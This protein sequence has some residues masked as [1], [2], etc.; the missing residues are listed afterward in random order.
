MRPLRIFAVLGAVA[1]AWTALPAAAEPPALRV[2]VACTL[3]GTCTLQHYVDTAPDQ[4]V[5]DYRCGRLSYQGHEGTDIRVPT[6]AAM[7][8]GVP[9]IAA[10][11][12]QVKAV[13]DGMPDAFKDQLTAE[14]LADRD[15]GNGVLIA[16]GDGWVTQ[17]S[18]LRLGSIAVQP[19]ERVAAGDRL[20]TIGLSGNTEFPHVEFEVRRDGTVVDPFTGA[21]KEAGCGADGRGLWTAEAR[22]RLSYEAGGLLAAGFAAGKVS[23]RD[24]VGRGVRAKAVT[25]DAEA[26]VFYALSYGLQPGDRERVVLRGPDGTVLAED[27]NELADHSAQRIRY[28]GTRTEA[29]PAGAYTARYTVTRTGDGGRSTVVDVR[30]ELS[31]R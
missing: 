29:G 31:V 13:R 20:G 21:A 19:G 25:R 30:R 6:V 12:G 14:T 27:T 15:A 7:H 2:P 17:Y 11:P 4:R 8:A 18:H 26:V 10:A 3:G 22:E 5:R 28:I 1:L 9:V 23:A 24:V 16:H